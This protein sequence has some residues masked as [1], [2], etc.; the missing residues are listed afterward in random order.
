MTAT[1]PPQQAPV[2][3]TKEIQSPRFLW[4]AA[5]TVV[6]S[7]ALVL[8][9]RQA[10]VRIVHPSPAFVPLTPGPPVLDTVVCV[11]AAIFV[12]LK[13]A[14]HE[15]P[16]RTWLFVSTP[17][18]I[19]SF[20]P[21]VMLARSHEMGCRWPDACALMIMHVVVWAVCVTLLPALAFSK[22]ASDQENRSDTFL[23]LR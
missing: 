6:V 8:V 7:V 2:E 4:V 22:R 17:I 23:S 13:F 14:H 10:A 12:F 16:E 18:L 21:D 3:F 11:I 20:L 1:D 5:L 19:L 9:V 15:N